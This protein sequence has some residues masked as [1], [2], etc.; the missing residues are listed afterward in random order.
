[1]NQ[2]SSII[3]YLTTMSRNIS[4]PYERNVYLSFRILG[5]VVVEILEY[6]IYFIILYRIQNHRG[7][8]DFVLRK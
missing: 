8:C 1:M 3:Q 2:R 6:I 5:I 4:L 7:P